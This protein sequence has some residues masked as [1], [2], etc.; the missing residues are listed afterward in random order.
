[1]ITPLVSLL[2]GNVEKSKR[3]LKTVNIEGKKCSYLLNKLRNLNAIFTKNVA[4]DNT[5]SLKKQC[6]TLSLENAFFEKP[7]GRGSK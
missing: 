4:Y 3:S 6:F 1:M 7:E 2:Q 5:E